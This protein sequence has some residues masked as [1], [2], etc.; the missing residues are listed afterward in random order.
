MAS[1]SSNSTIT[2]KRPSEDHLLAKDINILDRLVWIKY[3]SHWWPAIIYKSYS[4]VQQHLYRYLDTI[5]K[6]QFAMAI[7]IE[8]S[9]NKP[10]KVARILG[11]PSVELVAVEEDG[12]QEFYWNLAKMI[13]DG[14][15]L[16]R[17]V[18][19][20]DRYLEFHQAMDEIV[21]IFTIYSRKQDFPLLLP[22]SGNRTWYE[23]AVATVD[24]WTDVPIE[25]RRAS[26]NRDVPI[27]YE[28]THG[29]SR[30]GS[31]SGVQASCLKKNRKWAS[32]SSPSQRKSA[33]GGI[34]VDEDEYQ[35]NNFNKDHHRDA[36]GTVVWPRSV[37]FTSKKP[38]QKFGRAQAVVGKTKS[39]D[40]K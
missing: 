1:V 5:L 36:I 10:R 19:N 8:M 2:M 24:E 37:Q 31:N 17:F 3:E 20:V 12:Y 26:E 9:S 6:T 7:M 16:S 28:R 30:D 29:G 22:D 14:C 34:R 38:S 23:I 25:S 11:K 32:T 15:D 33:L 4:E 18:D 35:N 27:D 13:R 21:E 39:G 40:I